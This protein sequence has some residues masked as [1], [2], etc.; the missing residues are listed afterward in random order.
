MQPMVAMLGQPTYAG[1]YCCV[2]VC[3]LKVGTNCTQIV[4]L[5]G[6]LKVAGLRFELSKRCTLVALAAK[7]T[8]CSAVASL[9]PDTNGPAPWKKMG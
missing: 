2:R 6:K 7:D 5:N 8:N 1:K 3:I 4:C 9:Q